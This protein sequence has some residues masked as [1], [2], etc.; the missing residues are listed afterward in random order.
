MRRGAVVVGVVASLAGYAVLLALLR[1]QTGQLAQLP[2]SD[3]WSWLQADPERALLLGLSCVA[4]LV[5]AWLFVVTGL[6]LVAATSG[7]GAR[8]A[9]RVVP[10]IAPFAIRRTLEAALATA[11]DSVSSLSDK[12]DA[13]AA[14]VPAVTPPA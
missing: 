2:Y 11:Q 3:W 6:S 8:L 7:S 1:P 9:K 10:R 12:V 5:A 13:T 14:L 4:W